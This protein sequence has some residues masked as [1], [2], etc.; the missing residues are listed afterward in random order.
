MSEVLFDMIKRENYSLTN[1]D[2]MIRI[3]SVHR[4]SQ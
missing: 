3:I 2:N 1:E 4:E